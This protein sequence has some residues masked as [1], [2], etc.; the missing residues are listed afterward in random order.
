[1]LAMCGHNVCESDLLSS[2][3]VIGIKTAQTLKL[4]TLGGQ[5]KLLEGSAQRDQLGKERLQDVE[6]GKRLWW[7]LAQEVSQLGRDRTDSRIGLASHF[8]ECGVS[9]LHRMLGLT[10]VVHQDQFDTPMPSNCHDHDLVE[11]K[12]I[13]RPTT[14]LTVAL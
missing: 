2:L 12:A 11:G 10:L 3:L 1:M 5:A 9:D 8:E 6:L 14:E 13:D 7:A 4:H